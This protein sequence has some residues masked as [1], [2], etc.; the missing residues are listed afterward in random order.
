MIAQLNDIAQVWWQWMGS[1]FWQVGLFI[2]FITALDMIIRKWAWPQVR[3]AL[4]ALVFIKLIITPAWQMPTS[5]VAW[6][7]PQVK[8]WTLF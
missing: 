6:V 7:Q 1:M 3:Y 5:I 8:P 4:W 2:I